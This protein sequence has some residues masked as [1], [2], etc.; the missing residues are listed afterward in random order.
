M[1]GKI[2]K[3]S[4]C[5]VYR[6]RSGFGGPLGRGFGWLQSLEGVFCSLLVG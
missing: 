2:P 1:A 5:V 4:G 6:M 3:P